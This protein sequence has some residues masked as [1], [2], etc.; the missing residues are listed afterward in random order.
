MILKKNKYPCISKEINE[1]K[2][3]SNWG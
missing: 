1:L 2:L 3:G